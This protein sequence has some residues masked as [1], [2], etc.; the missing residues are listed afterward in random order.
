MAE[1][2]FD[3]AQVAEALL[4][5]P[6]DAVVPLQTSGRNSRLYRVQAGAKAF[7]LKHYV[8]RSGADQRDR[9]G[10]EMGALE[11]MESQG[12]TCVPR[13]LASSVALGCV[14]MSWVE[15]Q[16]V[17]RPDERDIDAALD[18][19]ARIHASSRCIAAAGQPPASEAC[20][21]GAEI[22][23]QLSQ[24]QNRLAAAARDDAALAAFLKRFS[25]FLAERILPPLEHSY[26]AMGL[27]VAE[28]LPANLRSLCPSDFGFHNALRDAGGLVFLDFDYFGWD[29][30][31]QMVC[32]FLL[33][34]GMELSEGLKRRFAMGAQHVYG[35][36][37][38]FAR[39]LNLLFALF[40]LRWCLILLN[41]FLPE[42]WA[43]RLHAGF[44]DDWSRVKRVHLERA[45]KLFDLT[46]TIFP[47]C[48]TDL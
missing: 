43:T 37:G 4:G 13:P 20:L 5:A 8:A 11:L 30:P 45:Q 48:P 18:F 23:T 24:R 34:P 47:H 33:H 22:V 14:L 3:P 2:A 10:T 36:D 7:C 44:Q 39:R 9:L 1:G 15:G 31:V 6:V 29:D 46:E 12:I 42:R 19:L 17:G 38:T 26:C 32:D 27:S 25:R 16:L 21:S 40:A 28:A 41:E 35:M